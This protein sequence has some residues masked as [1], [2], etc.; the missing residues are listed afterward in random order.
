LTE[1]GRVDVLGDDDRLTSSPRE[2]QPLNRA[3]RIGEYTFVDRDD[4]GGCPQS[5]DDASHIDDD[6]AP[7][8]GRPKHN[9]HLNLRPRAFLHS[10]WIRHART[11]P[12]RVARTRSAPS[13]T[14][15]D[16]NVTRSKPIAAVS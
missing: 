14:T 8:H 13:S 9:H 11:T 10:S 1:R 12:P 6:A 4:V 3:G 16:L 7:E 5:R 15:V 2:V